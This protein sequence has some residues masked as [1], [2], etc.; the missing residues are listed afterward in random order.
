M[1]NL[2]FFTGGYERFVSQ[3]PDF[4]LKS[5]SLA[6][7]AAQSST[8]ASCSSCTTPQHDQVTFR[9]ISFAFRLTSMPG[10]LGL[11]LGNSNVQERISW[12]TVTWTAKCGLNAR[13]IGA[14]KLLFFRP[15]AI[16]TRLCFIH[17]SFP[18]LSLKAGQRPQIN[19]AASGS[20]QANLIL[21]MRQIK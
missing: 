12:P 10:G 11:G 16:F 1:L 8:E 18:G 3:Y 5:K 15:V 21:H 14:I 9:S 2:L 4:C 13:S 7:P 17:P 6:T 19:M 20:G